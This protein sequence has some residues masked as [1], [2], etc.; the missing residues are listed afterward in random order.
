MS[1][2]RILPIGSGGGGIVPSG[3]LDIRS[4]G[5]F[6]VTNY[7][8]VDV[9]IFDDT[10]TKTVTDNGVYNAEDDH[11]LGYSQVTVQVP[12]SAVVSGTLHITQNGNS[13]DVTDYQYVD[14]DV[15]VVPQEPDYFCI[16]N[17]ATGYLSVDLEDD[18]WETTGNPAPRPVVYYSTDKTN[19]TL[20]TNSV[21]VPMTSRMYFYGENPLGFRAWKFKCT[22]SLYEV[23]GNIQTLIDR[24]ATRTDVPAYGF[25][26]L[27]TGESNLVSAEHLEL[28][29]TV[30]GEQSCANMFRNCNRLTTAPAT[31]NATV[32][33]NLCCTYM[34]Q[35]CTSLVNAPALPATTLANSCYSG[36]FSSCSA[37]T[38]APAL[39]ATTLANSCYSGMFYGCTSL[40]TTPILPATTLAEACYGSMFQ[41]CTSLVNAPALPATTLATQCYD[42]MFLDCT[43][44]VNA[45]ALPATTL[46]NSCY[47]Y[48]FQYCT[49]L[50]KAP[51]LPA[52]TLAD[53][54]YSGMFRYCTSLNEV[55]LSYA[56]QDWFNTEDPYNPQ[57][58]YSWGWLENVAATGTIYNEGG[59]NIGSYTNNASA[60]PSGWNVLDKYYFYIDNQNPRAQTLNAVPISASADLTLITGLEYSTDATNWTS[61]TATDSQTMPSVSIP[62]NG[63]LYL[64][65]SSPLNTSSTQGVS[66]RVTAAA[67]GD[68]VTLHGDIRTLVDYTDT[69]L[70][71]V[72]GAAFY[73]LFSQDGAGTM[74]YN[75]IIDASDIDFSRLR[76]VASMSNMFNNNQYLSGAPDLSS[77]TAREEMSTSCNY[78]YMYF[79]CT[80]LTDITVPKRPSTNPNWDYY[81]SN[82]WV[83]NVASTGT[84]H[85]P[86]GMTIS[87]GDNGIPA[88]WT[89]VDY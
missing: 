36:M 88:N 26:A 65:T 50:V 48:M 73:K 86:T 21:T 43:S 74:V 13:I 84:M 69:N 5:T 57:P 27:F 24:Y 79:N 45:P 12:A 59:C 6:D 39:P 4:E 75:S 14:V 41:Y 37:L 54:C 8:E 40:V 47:S 2:Y 25:L 23:A 28:P 7:A 81:T 34:F 33:S 56:G 42:S 3:T 11:V 17:T 60:V 71:N 89:R 1:K 64:R 30:L 82:S 66:L 10:T 29:A 18:S 9:D 31:L 77:I 72:Y 62:A 70:T 58:T 87:T 15:S 19:W 22:G 20:L 67:V 55:H 80:R 52:T 44:L 61:W 35:G 49:S 85:V 76:N 63:K 16:I 83:Y 32:L 46:A 68:G 78:G 51:V 38:S 53:S